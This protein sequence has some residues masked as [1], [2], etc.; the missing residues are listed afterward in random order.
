MSFKRMS[1]CR[2]SFLGL[3]AK[4]D[5]GER[6]WCSVW[7]KNPTHPH[8][9]FNFIGLLSPSI[10]GLRSSRPISLGSRDCEGSPKL[11]LISSHT[12]SF[13]LRPLLHPRKVPSSFLLLAPTFA[14]GFEISTLKGT[15]PET[16]VRMTVRLYSLYELVIVADCGFKHPKGLGWPLPARVCHLARLASRMG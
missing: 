4:G 5:S 6:C 16:K 13:R 15:L 7:Y 12:L 9:P 1:L 8:S 3:S 14:K 2:V 10:D 11:P